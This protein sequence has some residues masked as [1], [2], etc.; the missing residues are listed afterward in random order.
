[1]RQALDRMLE[2]ET[3]NEALDM[4]RAVISAQE[5]V[6][7]QTKAEQKKKLRELIEE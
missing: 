7:E 3:F 5:K 1:M 2:L 6:N 4:L